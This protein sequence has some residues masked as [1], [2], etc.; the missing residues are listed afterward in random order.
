MVN[1]GEL[2]RPSG[3]GDVDSLFASRVDALKC[4]ARALDGLRDE[5]R[6]VINRTSGYLSRPFTLQDETPQAVAFK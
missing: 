3:G 1:L 5:I 4:Q 2:E 6:G